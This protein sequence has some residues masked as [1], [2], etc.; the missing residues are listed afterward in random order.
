MAKR[1]HRRVSGGGIIGEM[2]AMAASA[3]IGGSEK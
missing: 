3:V 2:A 1:Q